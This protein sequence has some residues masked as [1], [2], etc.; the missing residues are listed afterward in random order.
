M[1]FDALR[2]ALFAPLNLKDCGNCDHSELWHEATVGKCH[3]DDC[4]CSS[5]F[6]MQSIDVAAAEGTDPLSGKRAGGHDTD[7][8]YTASATGQT[9]TSRTRDSG[10]PAVHVELISIPA[11][12]AIARS[13]REGNA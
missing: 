4:G 11:P 9:V 13:N 2:A 6:E 1:F 8:S 3:S 10:R 12:N 5:F 7:I